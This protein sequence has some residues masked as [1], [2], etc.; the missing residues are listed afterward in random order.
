MNY[1][2]DTS[3]WY[4][5]FAKPEAHITSKKSRL[6]VYDSKNIYLKDGTNFEIE[7]HNPTT[8]KYMAKIWING[9]LVSSSGIVVKPGQRVYL[10]RFIDENAKFVF[11]TFEVD[12]VEETQQARDRNGLVKV[13]FYPE[14]VKWNT[15]SITTISTPVFYDAQKFTNPNNGMIGYSTT[16]YYSSTSFSNNASNT[17]AGP[18]IRTTGLGKQ[19]L[20]DQVETGRV[21]HGEESDQKFSSTTGDFTAYPLYMY[22]VH[23]LPESLKA[24]EAN[25]IRSYCPECGARVKKSNWKYC[26]TCGE[27]L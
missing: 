21:A 19:L 20:N 9:K 8:V 24:V 27:K 11:K 18:N 6:K 14:L 13:E 10:E 25:E 12:N 7:L 26:P 3:S 2:T 16:S 17:F 4:S 23:L 1:T 15:G 22:E 5:A